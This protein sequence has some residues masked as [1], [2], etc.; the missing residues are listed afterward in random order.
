MFAKI[1]RGFLAVSVVA[2][3]ASCNSSAPT[4]GLTPTA[5]AGQAATPVVQ[6]FCPPVV[7][8]EQTAI[9]RAYARGGEN[10]PEKLLYQ[11]SLADAT[12]QCTANETT[13]TINVVAQGRVVQGPVGVPG[14]VTLPVLVEVVDGDSVIY[15][16]KVAF[17]VDMPAGGTQFIFNKADV[18][19]PNAQGGASRFTRV[20]LGFD[21]GPAKKPVR[22]N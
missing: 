9:H 1:S 12:R 11:A 7:M 2:V 21:T 3:L 13:L 22:R 6:A 14:K 19:I 20:R 5:P 4:E 17:P 18:Q 10:Q 16:Q 15:S 8:L